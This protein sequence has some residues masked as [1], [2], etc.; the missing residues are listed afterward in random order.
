MTDIETVAKVFLI[1]ERMIDLT[2][3]LK[4]EKNIII[5]SKEP[6]KLKNT[7]NSYNVHLPVLTIKGFN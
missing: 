6:K 2:Y 5:S 3:D 1:E 4:P 7:H